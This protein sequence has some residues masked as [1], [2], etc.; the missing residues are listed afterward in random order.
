[1][2]T[3][4]NIGEQ[5]KRL[6]RPP[7]SQKGVSPQQPSLSHPELGQGHTSP[8]PTGKGV[9]D[10]EQLAYAI[11]EEQLSPFSSLLRNILWHNRPEIERVAQELGVADNTIYRWMSGR[12]EPRP[13]H[14]KKLPD[15]LP[16]QRGN[17]LYAINKT[18]PGVLEIH[19]SGIGEVQKD[20]YR[21]V[22]ELVATIVEDDARLWQISEAIFEYAL[23]HLDPQYQGL[24]ITYAKLMPP[25][26]DGIHSLREAA[27][28]GNYPWPA[29]LDC[30][31]YL[32]STTLACT[33]AM[34][35]QPQTW[36]HLK[37]EARLQAVV[38]ENE[39]SACACPVMRA[40]RLAGVLIIS[41]TQPN[42][43]NDPIAHQTIVEYARLLALAL[44][45]AD[46]QPP[47]LLNF[48]P[49][50]DLK[51]QRAEI[52]RSY[53]NRIVTTARKYGISRQE[54]EQRVI[55]DM[56]LEFEDIAHHAAMQQQ[57][58]VEQLHDV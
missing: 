47:S 17:L 28:R 40:G 8:P 49:M 29:T 2:G 25:H 18:F 51:W 56:E 16:E 32:G 48:R 43:F 42:F 21:R 33:A 1:M 57:L 46:F 34:L 14:L 45:D 3:G 15:A 20:I 13:A 50:P 7:G 41:S 12:T 5:P 6:G 54:V 52:R 38:D 24:A 11:A 4:Q 53:V 9:G 10:D 30:K 19:S 37:Q 39:R 44:R 23:L 27:M 55:Q 35:Q 26:T 36:D 58:Q 22:L 31:A